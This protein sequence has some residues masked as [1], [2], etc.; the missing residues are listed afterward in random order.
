MLQSKVP[1]GPCCP[2]QNDLLHTEYARL[3][4]GVMRCDASAA[5]SEPQQLEGMR[6]RQVL[7]DLAA[8]N[9]DN[10]QL[11]EEQVE[12]GGLGLGLGRWGRGCGCLG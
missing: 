6:F 2:L 1:P 5:G 12:V 10:M 7:E 9:M 3:E 11:K 4:N 8:S